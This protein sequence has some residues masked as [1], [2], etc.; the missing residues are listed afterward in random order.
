METKGAGV[1][2]ARKSED[3]N[4]S[5]KYLS[6]EKSNHAFVGGH[7]CAITLLILHSNILW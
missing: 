2:R 5:N 3:Q 7:L 6:N 1:Y 4:K